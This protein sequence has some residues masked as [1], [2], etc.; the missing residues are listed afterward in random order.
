MKTV[1]F[2]IEYNGAN[3]CGWQHQDGQRSVQTELRKA[4][5]TVFRSEPL[6]LTASGRT[7]SG[8]HAAGQVVSFKTTGD[9]SNLSRV[10]YGVSSLMREE[11]T[12]L[13][14][15]IMKDDFN[16]RFTPH[17]KQYLYRIFRRR[18][19]PILLKDFVW[20]IPIPLD[21]ARMKEEAACIIGHHDFTSFRS[22]DCC[23]KSA[24]R[25][26]EESEIIEDGNELIYRV[27]ARSFLKQMVRNITGTLVAIGSGKMTDQTVNSL[28]EVKDRRKAG[29]TAP[30]HG[31]VLDWVRYQ[32][33]SSPT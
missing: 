13:D 26:I 11:L 25:T 14:A 22:T 17:V 31:L 2:T 5:T 27:V 12:V 29:M 4:L 10:A 23:A 32:E 24:V 15:E 9:C 3:F 1:K 6:E 18:Q 20:H 33:S 7:D 8:V 28:Y 30:A 16:A 19:A 21:V